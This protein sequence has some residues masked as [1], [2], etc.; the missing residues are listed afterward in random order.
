MTLRKPIT[1]HRPATAEDIGYGKT[2][3]LWCS[4]TAK[5]L[6]LHPLKIGKAKLREVSA[7]VGDNAFDHDNRR[8]EFS[9]QMIDEMRKAVGCYWV[10]K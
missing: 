8:H 7:K 9:Q 2:I 6:K 5:E 1:T 3:Y 4:D 10:E